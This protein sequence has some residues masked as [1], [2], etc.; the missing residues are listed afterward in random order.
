MRQNK[1]SE[2]Y[3][4]ARLTGKWDGYTYVECHR[5][6]LFWRQMKMT[7]MKPIAEYSDFGNS[8]RNILHG[9]Q[10]LDAIGMFLPTKL[11]RSWTAGP[12]TYCLTVGKS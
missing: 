8:I 4:L 6:F 1:C 3:V 9:K 12:D 11:I 2:L 5:F 7:L 10:R